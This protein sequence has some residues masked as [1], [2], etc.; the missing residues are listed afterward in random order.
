MRI[1]VTGGSGFLGGAIV[2]HLEAIGMIDDSDDLFIVDI[3][4]PTYETEAIFI[5]H[6][7]IESMKKI[8]GPYDVVF[9]CAGLLGSETLFDNIVESAQVNIIGTLNVLELQ[10]NYG[11]IIQPGLMGNWLNPYMIPKNTAE[12][13]GF[14]YRKQY[15]TKYISIRPTDIYGPGQSLE[16]K[17]ITPTFIVAALKNEP[18]PIYGSGEYMVNMLFVRDIAA[19]FVDTMEEPGGLQQINIASQQPSNY[20][21]VKD[22]AEMIVNLCKS[23]SG[24]KYL[25]M[26]SGQPDTSRDWY[27]GVGNKHFEHVSLQQG[28]LKA[29]QYYRDLICC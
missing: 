2:R 4:K 11:L 12:K 17:K 16:Q 8:G 23:S 21:S 24:L 29:I 18:L 13:Y 22:Y 10:K 26:R 20:L 25:P 14:M 7:V 6:N 19:F 27:A 1:L 3:V 28:L 9:H 15:G 5:E